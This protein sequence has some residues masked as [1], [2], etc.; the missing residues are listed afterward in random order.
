MYSKAGCQRDEGFAV[1]T[2]GNQVSPLNDKE[3]VFLFLCFF[4]E[5][6]KEKKLDYS[7][8]NFNLNPFQPHL[9]QPQKNI[10]YLLYDGF[11]SFQN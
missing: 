7:S 2:V 10:H 9:Q 6:L 3:G 11:Q 4:L 1:V 5:A 8:G